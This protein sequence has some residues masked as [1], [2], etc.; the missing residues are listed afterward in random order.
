MKSITFV[1]ILFLIANSFASENLICKDVK[2]SNLSYEVTSTR[3]PDVYSLVVFD[4]KAV[5]SENLKYLDW[6]GVAEYSLG[7]SN[8]E[9]DYSCQYQTDEEL[10]VGGDIR[11]VSCNGTRQILVRGG[12]MVQSNFE[13]LF[14]FE[15]MLLDSIFWQVTYERC[16]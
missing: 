4:S 8:Q 11:I 13:C 14:T 6:Q 5:Y 15:P 2:N 9:G 10:E 3:Q 12:Y 1:A 7:D 16:Q